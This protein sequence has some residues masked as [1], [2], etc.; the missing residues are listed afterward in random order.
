MRKNGGKMVKGV[1]ISLVQNCEKWHVYI[2]FVNEWEHLDCE[3]S[4]TF[5][6]GWKLI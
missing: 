1:N 6:N 2:G 5:I 3:P 4:K